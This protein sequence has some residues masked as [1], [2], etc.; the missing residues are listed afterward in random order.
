MA[1]SAKE[2]I[3]LLNGMAEGKYNV[4]T[5]VLGHAANTIE[6]LAAALDPFARYYEMRLSATNDKTAVIGDLC[7]G[8]FK[9]AALLTGSR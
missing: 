4:D 9:R 3:T 6:E 8:D 5:H 1:I 2:L 7:A